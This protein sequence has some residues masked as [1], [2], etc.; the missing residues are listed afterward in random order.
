M[1]LLPL[2]LAAAGCSSLRYYAHVAHGEVALLARR[3][4]IER[5]VGDVR[6]DPSVRERLRG[7]LAARRFA[8]DRLD[9]PRNRSYAS[10]VQLDR[11]FVTWSVF[12]APEF[13]VEPLTHCFPFAGCVGYLGYFD[14]ARAE[15]AAEELARAGYDTAVR[16]VAAY[17]TLGWFA[18][19][20]VSS[21]LRGGDDELDR[22][23]F[24]ELAHQKVYARDDTAFNESYASFVADEGLREWRA[25]NGRVAADAGPDH[26]DG[27]TRL[28]LDLRERLRSL[29]ASSRDAAA[30][31]RDKAAAIDAFRRRLRELRDG[32]WHG[33]HAYDA[34][35]SAPINNASLVPFGL[36]D[37]WLDAFAALF[38]ASAGDWSVFHARVRDLARR[39]R[40]IRERGLEALQAA[41][42]D[43]RAH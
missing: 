27:F 18:D 15:R 25:A 2:L 26:D 31:R 12:A 1:P 8:S 9:L 4:P 17:S 11:P 21:M 40:D 34:W 41:A 32:E 38:D 29:Y 6:L 16:G 13:S 24:H 36:Y 43:G 5:A 30:M 35:I 10:Y 39:P 37:R 3:E 33:D 14:H 23:I 20:I 28:A 22:V 42:Q 19:P 7:A